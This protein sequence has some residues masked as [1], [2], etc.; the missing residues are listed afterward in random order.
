MKI[1]IPAILAILLA[2]CGGGHSP[3]QTEAASLPP[4]TVQTVTVQ[5]VDWPVTYEAP[6]TVRARTSAVLSSRVMGYIREIRAEPGDRVGAGQLL[7]TMVSKDLE[8]AVRQAEAAENEARSAI[9]EADNGIASAR[10]QLALAQSTFRR[11]DTLHKQ[12]SISDQEFD[13]AQARLRTAQAALEMAQGKRSQLEAKIAQAKQG[14]ASAGVMQS[15][16][17]IHAPFAGRVIEKTAQPG[18]LATPG[19]PLLTIEKAGGYRLEAP[20]EESLL[21]TI[22][23]GQKAKVALD[24]YTQTLDARVEEIVPAVDAQS[25]AFLVKAALPAAPNLQSGLYGRLLIERSHRQS[26]V[27]PVEAIRERGEL[28]SV[29]V[30]ENGIARTRMLTVGSRRNGNAEVLSG[31]EAGERV[32]HPVPANLADGMKVEVR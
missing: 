21:G 14:V 10:A 12:T 27:V 2:G 29:F 28:Q 23:V 7:V 18:Q 26:V 22:R 30:A 4:V 19:A 8:A 15:Y 17:R 20:V 3:R 16:S 5:S 31:L 1:V 32:V 24:A 9:A 25:R 11:M 13:E 6:G